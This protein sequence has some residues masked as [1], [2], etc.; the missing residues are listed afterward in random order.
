MLLTK[1]IVLGHHISPIGIKVDL[2][3]IEVIPNLHV[4]KTHKDVCNFLEHVDYY[5]HVIENLTNNASPLFLLLS[6]YE[7][8][9]WTKISVNLLLKP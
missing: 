3:K 4:P 9:S 6:K 7:K 2:A 8:I 1:G 5:R